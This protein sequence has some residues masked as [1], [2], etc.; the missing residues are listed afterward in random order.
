M[1]KKFLLVIPALA[2]AIGLV[3]L[4]FAATNVR[5]AASIGE[6]HQMNVALNKITGSTWTPV[7]DLSGQGMDFG[8]LTKGTDNVF[9][10]STYFV[11]DAPVF[12][13]H[14]SWSITHTA[15]DFTNGTTNLN[16]NVNV[17]FFR[18]DNTT[19]AAETQL[20]SNSYVSYQTSKTRAAILSSELTNARLRIYYSIAGGSGDAPGVTLITTTTPT[21]T[22]TGTVTLTLSP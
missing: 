6:V 19:S 5:I 3:P 11:V 7:T 8:T 16:N 14:S 18:V 10:S 1:K 12:S 21:G 20:A 13:N 2:I 4:C 9:R 15:T 17:T 22:Y